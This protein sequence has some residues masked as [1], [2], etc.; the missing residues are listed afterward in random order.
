MTVEYGK[1]QFDGGLMFNIE[2]TYLATELLVSDFW[3]SYDLPYTG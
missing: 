2:F 1:K 3:F